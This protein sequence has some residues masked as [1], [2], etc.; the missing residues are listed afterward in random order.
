MRSGKWMNT[1][2]RFCWTEAMKYF[3]I[4]VEMGKVRGFEP[5]NDYVSRRKSSRDLPGHANTTGN[6]RRP[7]T[8]LGS[9]SPAA[10]RTFHSR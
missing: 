8:P 6:G 5:Q 10:W 3:L 7:T 1:A 9:T 4:G 2:G